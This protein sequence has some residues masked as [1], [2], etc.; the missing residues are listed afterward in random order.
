MHV[1]HWLA[2]PNMACYILCTAP[3]QLILNLLILMQMGRTPCRRSG[4]VESSYL[5]RKTQDRKMWTC[6]HTDRNELNSWTFKNNEWKRYQRLQRNIIR[7]KFRTR[8]SIRLGQVN[9]RV[10]GQNRILD[11]PWVSEWMIE[12]MNEWMNEWIRLKRRG[13]SIAFGFL[14]LTNSVHFTSN[15]T[16][17]KN[18]I[19]KHFHFSTHLIPSSFIMRFLIKHSHWLIQNTDFSPLFW[20]SPV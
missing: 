7:K 1:L 17:P 18:N 20:Q 11:E 3:I 16:Q 19:F 15:C 13:P 14:I 8:K 5:H 12:W 10:L 2:C 4:P 9:K 6:I